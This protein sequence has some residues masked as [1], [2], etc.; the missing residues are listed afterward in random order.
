MLMEELL[1]KLINTYKFINDYLT[2]NIQYLNHFV[3][4]TLMRFWQMKSLVCKH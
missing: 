3:V 4:M 2:A 1:F